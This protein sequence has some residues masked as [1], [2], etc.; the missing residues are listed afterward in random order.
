MSSNGFNFVQL[1]FQVIVAP[2][3]KNRVIVFSSISGHLY[4]YAEDR[5]SNPGHP[6]FHL[7]GEISS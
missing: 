7:K 6:T 1:K 4:Y 2:K 3:K 5:D